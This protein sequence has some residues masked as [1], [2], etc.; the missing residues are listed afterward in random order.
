ML[1]YKK[2]KFALQ[3]PGARHTGE[4][5]AVVNTPQDSPMQW[6]NGESGQGHLAPFGSLCPR[7]LSHLLKL[8][9]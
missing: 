5:Q 2:Q 4:L 7:Q 8:R 3:I 9:D 1:D 6:E